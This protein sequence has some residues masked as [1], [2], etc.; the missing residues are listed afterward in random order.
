MLFMNLKQVIPSIVEAMLPRFSHEELGLAITLDLRDNFYYDDSEKNKSASTDVRFIFHRPSNYTKV[1]VNY[2]FNSFHDTKNNPMDNK[3]YFEKHSDHDSCWRTDG[4][5][6]LG[7]HR[8]NVEKYMGVSYNETNPFYS[9]S[10]FEPI[11][12]VRFQI[13]EPVKDEDNYITGYNIKV[14]S[15]SVNDYLKNIPNLN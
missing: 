8:N 4:V 5:K 3:V 12:Y 11:T 13:R 15:L 14:D 10:I 7:I 9:F 6:I 2:E 1:L